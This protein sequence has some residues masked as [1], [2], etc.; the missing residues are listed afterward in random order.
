MTSPAYAAPTRLDEAT[1]LLAGTESARPL[2]GGTDLMLHLRLGTAHPTLVV[3][4]TGIATISGI[5][6]RDGELVIGAATTM[7]QLLAHPS[8]HRRCAA[9]AQAA[10]RLGGQQMQA[11]A[12]LGGNLCNASPAAESATP[13]LALGA[14]AVI[15]GTNRQRR[16]PVRR[17]LTGP[18]TTALGPGELLTGIAIPMGP[19][20][21]SAYGRLDLRRSV[22]IAIVSCSVALTVD[23]TGSI[24]AAQIALGA[25]GP[26][27]FCAPAAAA[28]L[29]GL[30]V[31]NGQLDQGAIDRAARSCA[32]AASPIDDV[33]AS[34][35]YRRAMTRTMVGR[36]IHAALAQLGT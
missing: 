6:I 11:V 30:T 28:E 32:H 31:E 24:T 35:G 8:I 5:E 21:V 9:L 22:D 7:R 16:I 12:T 36:T 33:R 17:F 15:A 1:E 20:T 29:V 14:T 26:T 34:A 4:I 13:L 3:D 18:G 19:R 23:G 10:D 27:P 2:A 25:V